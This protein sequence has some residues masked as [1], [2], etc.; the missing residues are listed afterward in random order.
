MDD[1]YKQK[2]HEATERL[3]D[4]FNIDI[5]ITTFGEVCHYL[6]C[7]QLSYKELDDIDYLA[8]IWRDRICER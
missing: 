7:Q 1:Q 3:I 2:L 4:Y 5:G 6:K 8:D